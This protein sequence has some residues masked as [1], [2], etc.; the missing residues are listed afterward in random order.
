[1]STT[2]TA[3]QDIVQVIRERIANHLIPPGAKLIESEMAD[4]F[5]ISRTRVREVLTELELR[6]LIRREPNRGA[7]VA[8]LDLPEI[9]AIY[10]VREA[11]EGMAVR[12]ATLNAPPESWEYWLEQ[13]REGGPMQQHVDRGE[14]EA[15]F[16]QYDKLRGDIIAAAGNPV[17]SSMLDGILEKTRVIMRRVQILPGRVAQALQEHRAVLTAMRAGDAEEAERLRRENIRSAIATLK[18]F[19]SYII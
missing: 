2:E 15:Y 4:E 10:D 19:Q 6:G 12:L 8:R 7:V 3:E 13:F 1:M 14:I 17:L 11:L 5:G 9:F 18:R 16:K